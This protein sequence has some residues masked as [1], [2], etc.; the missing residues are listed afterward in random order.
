MA[1]A[2][3][4][5]ANGE[6]HRTFQAL[7][8]REIDEK[9]ELASQTFKFYRRSTLAE[10]ARKMNEA[11]RILEDEK[12]RFVDSDMRFSFKLLCVRHVRGEA[13]SLPIL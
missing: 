7:T 5:P 13:W 2:S 1:I 8:E 3:I 4:N 10:R 6:T 11:A 9:L 12:D